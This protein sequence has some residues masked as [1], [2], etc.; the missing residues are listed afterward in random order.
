MTGGF[1]FVS[2]VA[3]RGGT[4]FLVAGQEPV[5]RLWWDGERVPITYVFTNTRNFGEPWANALVRV[6]DDARLGWHRIRVRGPGGHATARVWVTSR[7]P[8]MEYPE[9]RC[10][11]RYADNPF[12]WVLPYLEVDASAEAIGLL[13][14]RLDGAERVLQPGAGTEMPGRFPFVVRVIGHDGTT[15]P[16]WLVD[17]KM[18]MG[19]WQPD[20]P[21]TVAPLA[22]SP[23]MYELWPSAPAPEAGG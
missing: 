20:T 6:G 23:G 1:L 2:T 10:S 14:W 22:P 7:A 18:P 13:V 21:C 5:A 15:G 19:W 12:S 11:M 17:A 8:S 9:V 16:A 3:V 4:V